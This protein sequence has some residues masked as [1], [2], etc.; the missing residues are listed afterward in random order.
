MKNGSLSTKLF[1]AVICAAVLLYFGINV[2]AYLMDPYTSTV[3]YNYTSEDAI[4]VAGYVVREEEP[5]SG[6]GELV[7]FS[8]SEGERVAKG[9]TVALVYGTTQAL[10]DANTLRSLNEQLQQLQYAQSLA[11]GTRTGILLEDEV[12]DS[13]ISFQ[14]ALT[15]RAVTEAAAAAEDLRAAVLKRSYAYT[16]TA[17]LDSTIAQLQ[18]RISSLTAASSASTSRI[19]APRSGLFSGMADGYETVLTP[20]ALEDMT[21]ADYRQIQ[22]AAAAGS[23]KLIYGSRWHFVTLLRESDMERMKV[24]DTVTLRFQ[25]GLDRDLTMTVERISDADGGQR[26]VVLSSGQYLDLTTLLRHQNAQI[27]FGSY[28]GIRVPRSAV[29]IEWEDVLDEDDQPVLQADG[30]A[31]REQ[32]TCVYTVWGTNARKKPVE[33]LWQEDEY[34]IVAP[35]EGVSSSRQLRSGDEVITAA[36]ELYDGKVI[37]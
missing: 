15:D 27:I 34:M 6:E 25:S 28:T 22:P 24:G 29:R 9:G 21:V 5:L 8:R 1:L 23:G 16:G 3:A 17:E 13:L 35:A 36:A 12:V 10:E 33:V 11:S 18:E 19:T 37:E 4:P 30:T 31:K 14:S 32:V 7:Y 2:A 26:L 20:A